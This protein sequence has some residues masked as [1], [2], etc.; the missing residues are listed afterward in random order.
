MPN[1][2]TPYEY[3][4]TKRIDELTKMYMQHVERS[5]FKV[6]HPCGRCRAWRC[7]TYGLSVVVIVLGWL[8]TLLY[9]TI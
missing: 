7:A 5:G 9:A 2:L 3:E 1:N 4:L 8:L 6:R